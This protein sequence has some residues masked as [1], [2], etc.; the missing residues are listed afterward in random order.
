LNRNAPAVVSDTAAA[1]SEEF[2]TYLVPVPRTSFVIRI[3][4]ENFD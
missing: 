1:V 4:Q 3:G 2:D